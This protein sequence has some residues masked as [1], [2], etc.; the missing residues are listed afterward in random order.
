MVLSGSAELLENSLPPQS[1]SSRYV[2]QIRRT[3]ERAAAITK[4]LLAFSRK[5][6]LEIEP[7]DLHEV[8]TDSEFMLPRLLACPSQ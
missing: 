7:I 2:E 1:V 5:Q 6:V 8:L 3:V 4:Q